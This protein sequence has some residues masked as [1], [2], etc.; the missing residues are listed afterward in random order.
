MTEKTSLTPEL[1]RCL[2]D[3]LHDVAYRLRLIALKSETASDRATLALLLHVG[4][5]LVA[6]A[7]RLEDQQ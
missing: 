6:T 7:Q 3:G 2:V 4:G 5:I 1:R